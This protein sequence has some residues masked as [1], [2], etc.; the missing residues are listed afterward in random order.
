[1]LFKRDPV[2]K[3]QGSDEGASESDIQETGIRSATMPT[4]WNSWHKCAVE[5]QEKVRRER[6]WEDMNSHL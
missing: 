2:L 4:G 5:L 3:G 1:M 6:D